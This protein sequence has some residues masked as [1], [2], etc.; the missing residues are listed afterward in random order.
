MAEL[1]ES[2]ARQ[3]ALLA[4]LLIAS[5]AKPADVAKI[6]DGV[7]RLDVPARPKPP[8]AAVPEPRVVDHGAVGEFFR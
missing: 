7:P 3:E 6:V 4:H 1:T 2:A 5:G 8:Q